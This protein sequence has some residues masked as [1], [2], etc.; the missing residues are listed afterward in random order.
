METTELAAAGVPS[1]VPVFLLTIYCYIWADVFEH[2]L[3]QLECLF[4]NFLN[5]S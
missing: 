1:H 3:S 5:S 4:Q 2:Y